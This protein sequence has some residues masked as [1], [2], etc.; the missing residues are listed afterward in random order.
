MSAE[1]EIISLCDLN[2]IGIHGHAGV[3]KDTAAAWLQ[4]TY[5]K[6]YGES[7]AAPLKTACAAAFGIP[8]KWFDDRTKKEEE[9]WYGK[10]PR[11]LAQ[12]VGTEIFRTHFPGHWIKLLQA[13]LTGISAPPPGEGYYEK[14]DTV[15]ITD[16]RFQDEADWIISN[17]GVLIEI[18]RADCTGAVGIPGH[19][20]EAGIDISNFGPS[21]YPI[22]NNG[23]LEEF[24]ATL[25]EVINFY[26]CNRGWNMK[27]NPT[28]GYTD[29]DF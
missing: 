16:E 9:T 10:S 7:F 26:N 17:G 6:V 29:G 23:T 21:Y 19:A 28:A 15:I 24:Y 12:Y 4:Q 2:L 11:A 18:H 22:V 25:E 8:R 1:S 5:E 20:S 3:G 27:K 14:G 13:R